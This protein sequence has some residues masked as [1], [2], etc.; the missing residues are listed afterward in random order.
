MSK[1]MTK[2]NV[3]MVRGQLFLEEDFQLWNL[4]GTREI[5]KHEAWGHFIDLVFFPQI[6]NLKKTSEKPKLGSIL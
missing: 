2:T 3:L 6:H 5:E 1:L 4:E